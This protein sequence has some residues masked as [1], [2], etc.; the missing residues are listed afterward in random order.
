MSGTLEILK[1]NNIPAEEW[2]MGTTKVFI[3]HPETVSY[4]NHISFK[5]LLTDIYIDLRIRKSSRQVLAQHGYSHSTC[6][7]SIFKIQD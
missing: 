1:H 3:R 4:T 5:K 7:E 6:L 2:Q